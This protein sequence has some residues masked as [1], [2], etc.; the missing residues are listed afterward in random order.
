MNRNLADL[1]LLEACCIFSNIYSPIVPSTKIDE[2]KVKY[3]RYNKSGE[4]EFSFTVLREDGKTKINGS[5]P[6]KVL[7]KLP[8]YGVGL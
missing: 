5:L 7:N 1:S 3:E 2:S 8:E 4:L 6:E